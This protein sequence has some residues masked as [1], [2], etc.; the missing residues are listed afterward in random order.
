LDELFTGVLASL[1]EKGLVSLEC[2]S[3]DGMR[4][5]ASAGADSFRREERLWEL[6]EQARGR[7]EELKKRLEDPGYGAEISA[8]QKAARERAARE[9]LERMEQ[10]VAQLPELQEA[11]KQLAG[12]CSEKQKEKMDKKQQ[13]RVSTT[14]PEVRRMKMPDGGFRPAVNVQLATDTCS[15]AIVGVEVSSRGVDNAGQGPQMCQQ[16]EERSGQK[17]GSHLM[18][19]GY[20]KTED[21]EQA[22]RQG[23]MVY[24]PPKPPRNT[25]KRASGCDP[26]AGDSQEVAEW[27]QRM[28]SEEGKEV[29]KLRASTSETVNADLRCFRGLGQL[30]VRGT[31]KIR[32]LA[33]WSAVA[34]NVMH[35]ATALIG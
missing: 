33:L 6:L 4:V 11:Q 18:D 26:M 3:Q 15:R 27:R 30:L 20:V 9:R 24:M 22:T 14:D 12:K 23:V 31:A 8:G 19:G 25:Q 16:A 34:Y 28:G 2:I 7:V 1:V 10:A 5:R 21:I 32:C 17:V 29:Y 13:P 35:F